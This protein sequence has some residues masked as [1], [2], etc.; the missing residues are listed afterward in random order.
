MIAVG[1]M[2]RSPQEEAPLYTALCHAAEQDTAHFDV[3]G[4]K[5]K[6]GSVLGEAFGDRVPQMDFNSTPELDMLGSPA[7]VIA[8][9]ETLLAHAYGAD[10]AFMLVNGSTSGV[11]YMILTALRPKEKVIL[12]RNVHKS[13]INALILSGAQPV[14]VDP[15]VDLHYGISNGMPLEGL[16]RAIREHPDA[17]AVFVINPTYFGAAG[18]LAEIVRLA[19][20]HKMAVLVDE[21]HGAHLPFHPALPVS[22]MAAGADMSTVSLHKTGGALTQSSALL[23]REH[24]FRRHQVRS[25]VNLFQTTSASYLLLAS[26]DLARRELATR[27]HEMLDRLLGQVADARA[28]IS[29]TPGL[30]VI[31]PAYC[32]GDGVF[33]YDPTKLVVRVNDLGLTGFEAYDILRKEYGVQCEL[34]ETYV[35]LAIVSLGDDAATL[36][37]LTD[38]LQDLSRRFYATRP[39]LR[40]SLR[41]V[42][43]RPKTVISPREAFY[44]NKR[45]VTLDE[46]VGEVCGE[47]IMIYPPGIPLAIPGERLTEEIIDFYRFYQAQGCVV[48]NDEEN[49]SLIKI[50]GE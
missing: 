23:L 27:G 44:S 24:F 16:R 25:T 19:H 15:E 7:G 2:K 12:P 45:L 20:R 30:E 22:A 31:G 38:A 17:K 33:G 32:N 36:R 21:A 26:I 14:F 37:R 42:T 8:E 3:P 48:V 47:S 18:N 29:A 43:Q 46:A 35:I 6:P 4:H 1:A 50:L 49:P 13:A 11:Q 34:A 39:Q 41:G 10:D 9:A 28:V 5:K 40:H